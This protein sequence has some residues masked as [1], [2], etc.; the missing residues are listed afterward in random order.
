[1]SA[2]QDGLQVIV[3]EVND[4][5]S[6][7]KS[8]WSLAWVI[9]AVIVPG[10]ADSARDTGSRSER[11]NVIEFVSVQEL[12]YQART[13]NA[14]S[15]EEGGRQ[16]EILDA[17][18]DTEP[19][20]DDFPCSFFSRSQS[21][22]STLIGPRVLLTAAHCLGE[23]TTAT[24][25]ADRT[26]FGR[27]TSAKEAGSQ[28][29]DL[30]LC[31]MQENV[32]CG[33]FERVNTDPSRARVGSRVSITGFGVTVRGGVL[34]RVLRRGEAEITAGP[35][36]RTSCLEIEGPAFLCPGDSGGGIFSQD[37]VLI[38][39]ASRADCNPTGIPDCVTST[40]TSESLAFLRRWAGNRPGRRICGLHPGVSNCRAQ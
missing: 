28:A 13:K 34:D 40:S 9:V 19:A 39:V 7:G 33:P 31:E 35:A 12:A 37:R 11:E 30:A 4:Q 15:L 27:C 25:R 21:C 8:V 24:I 1:M 14:R 18:G 5:M 16:E 10:C 38:G 6:S 29:L 36:P 32:A 22:S 2:E 3:M 20:A 17:G 23:T 26:V